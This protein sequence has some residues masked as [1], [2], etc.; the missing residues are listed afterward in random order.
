MCGLRFDLR[1][2]CMI[3]NFFVMFGHEAG[4][5]VLGSS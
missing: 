2:H 1:D 3:V 5:Y 4:E